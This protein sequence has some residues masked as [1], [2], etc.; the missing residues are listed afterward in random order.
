MY[1]ASQ[2]SVTRAGSPDYGNF[3]MYYTRLQDDGTWSSPKNLGH[4]INTKKD[5]VG[6]VVSTDGHLAYFTSDR[7]TKKVGGFDIYYFDLYEEARPKKV[8]MIK[9]EVTDEEG[10]PM[11]DAKVEISYKNSGESV[12]VKINGDDGKYAA[13]IKVEEE[14]DIMVTVKKEG[15]SFDTKL[16][17][18][19]EI[20]QIKKEE[21]TY[22]EESIPMEIGKIKVGKSFTIDNILFATNSYDLNVDSK[23]ILDQ[24]IKFLKENPTVTVIIEGHTDDLGDDAQ[25]LTLSQNRANASMNYLISKGISKSRL[26]SKGYGETKPKVKNSSSANRAK[27]RRTDFMITG[28]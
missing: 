24:F 1:F 3:D 15:H 2:T 23:F 27:N 17:K 11:K 20:A 28:M 5:E 16:I 21:T 6:F 9:G 18:K 10:E 26:S 14:Q 25:N 22:I 8:I 4:P 13:I 12:E 7:E 19:E